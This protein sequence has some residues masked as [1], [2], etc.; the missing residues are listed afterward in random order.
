[1]QSAALEGAG[2][3][4]DPALCTRFGWTADDGARAAAALR[5]AAPPATA[6]VFCCDVAALGAIAWLAGRG[7]RVPQDVAVAGYDD[8]EMA[9]WTTPP[10]TTLA[11]RRDGLARLAWARLAAAFAGAPPP[12]GVEDVAAPLRPRAS[13]AAPPRLRWGVDPEGDI[14]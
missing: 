5:A 2:L 7:L 12:A 10:L 13:T 11:G 9:G 1:V 4:A 3:P 8:T 6:M 14:A